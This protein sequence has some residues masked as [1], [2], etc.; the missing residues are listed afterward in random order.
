M[1][2]DAVGGL[3]VMET[4]V[5]A[6]E[7]RAHVVRCRAHAT[8]L[9]TFVVEVVALGNRANEYLVNSN[10][11]RNVVAALRVPYN[12]VALGRSAL[13]HPAAFALYDPAQHPLTRFH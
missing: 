8:L 7:K 13:E 4:L 11:G 1:A 6:Y 12:A 10:M 9:T 3:G 5:I 2:I